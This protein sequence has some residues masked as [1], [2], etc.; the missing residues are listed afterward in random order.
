M[1]VIRLFALGLM[2]VLLMACEKP[3]ETE[4]SKPAEPA[5]VHPDYPMKAELVAGGVY[6]VIS[7]AR[8]FP[9]KENKGWNSNSSF[10][11]TNDGVLVVD[12]GS[13][14]AIGGALLK[15]IQTV[16]DKPVKWVVCTH[17]HGDHW[18]GTS[19]FMDEGVELIVSEKLAG[20]MENE[21]EYWSDLFNQMT[22]GFTGQATAVKPTTVLKQASRMTVGG[23]DVEFIPSGDSHS[24]GDTLVWLPKQKVL[25]SGDVVYSNRI[26]G[27]F[28]GKFEQWMKFLA[29]LEQLPLEKVIPGHG[30]VGTKADIA[31]MREFFTV[32]WETT[33][34]GFDEGLEAF[35]IVPLVLEKTAKYKSFYPGYDKYLPESVSHFYLQVEAAA[36]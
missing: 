20:R 24:A 28:E 31:R 33:A 27:T 3:A 13:S 23:L 32:I 34:T 12:T 36:F 8:D 17:G 30:E 9:N 10:V 15:T 19:A 7:P 25:I 16:T 18:L 21:L 35:E 14:E 4:V 26:P 1:K 29:E 11:V 6:A 22:E 5:P 2:A